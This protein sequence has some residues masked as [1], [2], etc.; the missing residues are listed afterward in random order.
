MEERAKEASAVNLGRPN[1]LIRNAEIVVAEKER[2]ERD[3]VDRVDGAQS[4]KAARKPQY[5]QDLR[6]R[7]DDSLIGN[8]TAR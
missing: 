8:E 5:P 2:C 1:Q 7:N 6:R 3:A 4:D